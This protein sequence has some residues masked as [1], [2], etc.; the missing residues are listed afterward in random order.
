MAGRP[1]C[2][3]TGLRQFACSF[4]LP[5]W[6][7]LAGDEETHFRHCNSA[8]EFSHRSHSIPV[9]SRLLRAFSDPRV[10]G[11]AG[12]VSLGSRAHTR[13]ERA[14]RQRG[15]RRANSILVATQPRL[16]AL[17]LGHVQLEQP[18][19]IQSEDFHALRLIEMAHRAFDRLGRMWPCPFVVGIVVG[20]HEVVDQVELDR[21]LQ[22][23][24]V[25]LE[26]SKTMRAVVVA[27][28]PLKLGLPPEAWVAPRSGASDTPR[29]WL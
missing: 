28:E 12:Y 11:E 29:P 23:R 4:V 20:P 25:L 14:A 13:G 19:R 7:H 1:G 8:G 5:R 24:F 26:R 6:N 2:L 9:H 3:G 27:R 22:A 10:F 17:V 21:V 16:L 18:R 15:V